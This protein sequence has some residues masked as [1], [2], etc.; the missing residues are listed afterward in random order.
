VRRARDDARPPARD[1]FGG[2]ARRFVSSRLF[3]SRLFSFLFAV[4]RRPARAR[5]R[6]SEAERVD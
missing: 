1:V 6:R 5:F 4:L 3:S 2:A